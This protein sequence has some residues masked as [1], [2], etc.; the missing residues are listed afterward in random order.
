M[1]KTRVMVVTRQKTQM[2]ITN[3]HLRMYQNIEIS[4]KI[5][6]AITCGEWGAGDRK[7]GTASHTL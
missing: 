5:L 3:L 4:V 6:T 2:P 7:E 1:V